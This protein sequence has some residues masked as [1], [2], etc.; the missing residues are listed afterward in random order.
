MG[1]PTLSQLAFPREGNPKFL[2]Q[3]SHWDTTVAKNVKRNVLLTQKV[4]S[5][6]RERRR[7]G[8]RRTRR[9]TRRRR[10]AFLG[11]EK[12]LAAQL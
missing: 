7:R 2:W 3:K 11:S 9:R 1:S 12:F 4:S 10:R 5:K 6:K 8:R